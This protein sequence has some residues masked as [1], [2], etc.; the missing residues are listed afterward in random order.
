MNIFKNLKKGL[1]VVT[2][3]AANI[4]G[5]FAD[6]IVKKMSFGN[7][8]S[9]VEVFVFTDWLCP[10]CHRYEPTLD[11]MAPELMKKARIT[12]IDLNPPIHAEASN[13]MPYNLS[14]IVNNKQSY[15]K[16]RQALTDLSNTTKNP[17]E[18]QIKQLATSIGT[19]YKPLSKDEIDQGL[20]IF[21][22]LSKSFQVN[23]T[24]TIIIINRETKNGQKFGNELTEEIAL[25]TID[26]LKNDKLPAESKN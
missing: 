5:V 8:D 16:F 4:N 9:S 12:F 22:I 21:Q 26:Y 1:L 6:N 14:F 18:E 20:K 2:L 7:E 25:K 15:L 10:F 19:N 24:P 23:S 11:K 13:F 17:T 3:L